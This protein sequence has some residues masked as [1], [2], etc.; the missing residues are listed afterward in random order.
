MAAKKQ[1]KSKSKAKKPGTR[2]PASKG[3]ATASSD[4][5][6]R[7][8]GVSTAAPS[9][10]TDRSTEA[11]MRKDA[12]NPSENKG[13]NK[14][15]EDRLADATQPAAISD[16]NSDADG[17]VDRLCGNYARAREGGAAGGRPSL[18]TPELGAEI[19]ELIACR[20]PLVKICA[21]DWMPSEMTI[22]RW[23]QSIPAFAANYEVARLHRAE[24]RQDYI[25]DIMRR[26]EAGLIKPDAAR[27][28]IDGEKWQAGK[29]QPKRYGDRVDHNL[30]VSFAGEFE[31]YIREINKEREATT[32]TESSGRAVA[33]EGVSANYARP[34]EAIPHF[35]ANGHGQD[36]AIVPT[37]DRRRTYLG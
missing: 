26:L 15:A 29:E 7:N 8:S 16:G 36:G 25:D 31:T 24:A 10:N 20:V 28:L 19:C 33:N 32:V 11:I 2:K 34:R 9:E 17:L 35:S 12:S 13:R 14:G 21:Y 1:T 5:T 3:K 23:R 18:Y 6:E 4:S 22:L 37:V 30:N 27:V